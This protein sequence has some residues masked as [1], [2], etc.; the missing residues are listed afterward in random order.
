MLEATSLFLREGLGSAPEVLAG[1]GSGSA[2]AR[3]PDSTR[4]PV[5]ILTVTAAE[6]GTA[7]VADPKLTPSPRSTDSIPDTLLEVLKDL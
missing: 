2:E 1:S 4:R 6:L 3:C 7:I 5:G